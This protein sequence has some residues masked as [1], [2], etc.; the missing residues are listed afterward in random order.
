MNEVELLRLE[1]A[2]TSEQ[3]HAKIDQ[4]ELTQEAMKGAFLL[5]LRH[6]A[7]KGS[8]NLDALHYDLG[9]LA[10]LQDDEGLRFEYE[11]LVDALQMLRGPA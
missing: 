6:L 3:L 7:A 2:E 11:A 8:A 1:V 4:Y 5:L 9:Q 10:D